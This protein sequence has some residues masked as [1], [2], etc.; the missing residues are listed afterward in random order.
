MILNA[1]H[2]VGIAAHALYSFVKEVYMRYL[3]ACALDAFRVNRV[4]VVLRG[5]FY[6]ARLEVKNRMV[7]TSVSEF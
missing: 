5:D 6:F 7:S 3:K 4:A 2:L 1:E